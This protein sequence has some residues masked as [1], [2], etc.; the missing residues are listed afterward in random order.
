MRRIADRALV[1][2]FL[3][4]LP[5]GLLVLGVIGER[6]REIPRLVLGLATAFVLACV[7]SRIFANESSP[8]ARFL[9]ALS[10]CSALPLLAVAIPWE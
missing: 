6:P 8:T 1:W 2:S 3:A 5:S 4:A 9:A 7:V 10:G